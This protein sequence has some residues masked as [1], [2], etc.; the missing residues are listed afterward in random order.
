MLRAFRQHQREAASLHRGDHV[1]AD[2]LIPARML[3]QCLV[4]PLELD[5]GVCRCEV[6]RPEA[7]RANQN[8]VNK[9]PRGRLLPGVV[10]VAHRTALHE[11]DRL[12]AVLAR[13]RGG[14]AGNVARL[15]ATGDQF[16]A[17]R[18]Q[19]MAMWWM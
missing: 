1:T 10:T 7:R 16:K 2:Q 9:R 5:S 15:G 8:V 11:D 3:S 4:E 17:A 14:E 19:M 6:R 12:M 18:R 13:G